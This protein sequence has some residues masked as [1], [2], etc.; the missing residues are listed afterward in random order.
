MVFVIPDFG[1]A[2]RARY[3][4]YILEI[5]SMM[6][7]MASRIPSVSGVSGFVLVRVTVTTSETGLRRLPPR[8]YL[9]SSMVNPYPCPL[10]TCVWPLLGFDFNWIAAL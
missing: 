5:L 6:I 8:S 7:L 3:E 9:R 10:D 2:V 4:L 1:C